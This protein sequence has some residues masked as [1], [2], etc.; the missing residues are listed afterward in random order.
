MSA[1]KVARQKAGCD[2]E[3]L[4]FHQKDRELIAKM[5]RSQLR[6]IKGGAEDP[7]EEPQSSQK[8]EEHDFKKAA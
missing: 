6:L 3:E 8:D 5:R 2:N 1:L 7:K 4:W